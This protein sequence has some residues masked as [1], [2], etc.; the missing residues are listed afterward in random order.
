MIT[1]MIS[2]FLFFFFSH[3]PFLRHPS[4]SLFPRM[5]SNFWSSGSIVYMFI[6]MVCPFFFPARS[7]AHSATL[8]TLSLSLSLSM[9]PRRSFFFFSSLCWFYFIIDRACLVNNLFFFFSTC[10]WLGNKIN[11]EPLTQR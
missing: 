4:L 3:L 2:F 11:N 5:N 9:L 7:L 1:V 6:R 8:S 10:Q